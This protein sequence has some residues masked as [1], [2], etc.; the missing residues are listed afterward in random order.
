MC[1]SLQEYLFAALVEITE[2]AAAHLQI[3]DFICVGGVG[4]NE[5]LQEMLKQMAAERNGQVGGM[6]ERYC[7]DNGAMISWCGIL[8]FQKGIQ[9]DPAE[10]GVNQRW[11]TDQLEILW[12]DE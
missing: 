1:Y 10:A 9:V 7:I 8:E 4:C 3:K 2:R 11:R 12:R 6:D 5:R